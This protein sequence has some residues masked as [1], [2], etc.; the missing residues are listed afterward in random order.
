MTDRPIIFS[1]DMVRA[2]LDGRKTQTRRKAWKR[3]SDGKSWEGSRWL[4]VKPGDKLWVREAWRTSDSL[5]DMS[6]RQIEAACLDA[7]YLG[8]W[9]PYL[10]EADNMAHFWGD[11]DC[12]VEMFGGFSR[13]AGRLRPAM[14]MPRW[15]SRITLTVT[16]VRIQKLQDITDA[17]V[18]A[19]GVT[20]PDWKLVDMYDVVRTAGTDLFQPLWDSLHKPPYS[21]ADNPEVVAI[22]FEVEK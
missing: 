4:G 17:E 5:D 18:V 7:G 6:P 19:E 12:G 10:T 14:H 15:A 20:I 21:W 13:D 11:E 9:C 3:A 8:P 1:D 16:T 2:L 22:S